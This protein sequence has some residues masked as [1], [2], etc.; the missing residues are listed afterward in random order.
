LLEPERGVDEWSAF[1]ALAQRFGGK[2]DVVQTTSF[3][4]TSESP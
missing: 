1:D 2:V 3:E 4:M